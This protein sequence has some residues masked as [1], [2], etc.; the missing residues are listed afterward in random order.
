MAC[1]SWGLNLSL[2]DI[3]LALLSLFLFSLYCC[4]LDGAPHIQVF[5]PQLKLSGGTYRETEKYISMVILI[6][7]S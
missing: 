2:Q 7:Q 3:M 1:V 6:Q 5:P 4:P